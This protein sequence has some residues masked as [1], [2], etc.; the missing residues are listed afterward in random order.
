MVFQ[1]DILAGASGSGGSYQIDQS[2][3]F[4]DDDSAYLSRNS[5]AS[6]AAYYIRF[7]STDKIRFRASTS[8]D[9]TTTQVFRDVSAWYHIV[10]TFENG[11]VTLYVNNESIATASVA[12]TTYNFFTNIIHSIGGSTTGASNCDLYLANTHG[13]DGQALAP[14]D[15]GETNDDGV[16]VPKAYT[17]A[18]IRH[19]RLLHHR[20]R[21]RRARHRLFRQR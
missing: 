18:Y 17:G 19:Q 4:N 20:R 12:D 3:R 5:G 11:A 10:A 2:I 1:N 9:I 8:W 15:F 16:W 14:T 6:A 7:E 21:Q 13:I